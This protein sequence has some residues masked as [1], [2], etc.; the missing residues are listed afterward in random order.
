MPKNDGSGESV[1]F[2]DLPESVQKLLTAISD[3]VSMGGLE[4]VSE[5]EM[6]GITREIEKHI[7]EVLDDN[8]DLLGAVAEVDEENGM[9]AIFGINEDGQTIEPALRVFALKSI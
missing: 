5:E 1:N 3:E 2:N 9:V 6:S 4:H 7:M 8:L